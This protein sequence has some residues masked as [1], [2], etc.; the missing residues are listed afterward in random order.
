MDTMSAIKE[1]ALTL[2]QTIKTRVEDCEYKVSQK[3]TADYVQ[4]LGKQIQANMID[5]VSI[6]TG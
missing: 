4:V 1:Q 2:E 3:V 6:L 5:S